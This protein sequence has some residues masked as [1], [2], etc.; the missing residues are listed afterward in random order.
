MSENNS[1]I[2]TIEWFIG[3]GYRSNRLRNGYKRAKEI[4]QVIK[5]Y[6]NG[7]KNT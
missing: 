6:S 2:D 1:C 3:N 4:A 5:E 7:T